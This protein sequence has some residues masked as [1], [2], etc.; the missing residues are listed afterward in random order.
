M[1][2]NAISWFQYNYDRR[3]ISWKC[4]S[5]SGHQSCGRKTQLFKPDII[6]YLEESNL[7]YEISTQVYLII[8]LV[9]S[10]NLKFLLPEY[11]DSLFTG[12]LKD[13]DPDQSQK[14]KIKKIVRDI[15]KNEWDKELRRIRRGGEKRKQKVRRWCRKIEYCVSKCKVIILEK[16]EKRKNCLKREG[17]GW[18]KSEYSGEM[19]KDVDRGKE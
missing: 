12:L 3:I 19:K 10:K 4:F 2:K 14:S 1:E 6:S 8:I 13:S 18:N 11:S 5:S 16:G 17:W 9:R 7:C 15:S